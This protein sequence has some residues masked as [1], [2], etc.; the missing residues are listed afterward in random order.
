[1][2]CYGPSY[3]QDDDDYQCGVPCR[4]GL[5]RPPS[6]TW[7]VSI[8]ASETEQFVRRGHSL[9]H[10]DCRCLHALPPVRSQQLGISPSSRRSGG[11]AL[12][13]A[14]AMTL[15][16]LALELALENPLSY[17][18]PLG[19]PLAPLLARFV[20]P[21]GRHVSAPR[22]GCVV[23]LLVEARRVWPRPIRLPL[24]SESYVGIGR[25][26]R[27]LVEQ[28]VVRVVAGEGCDLVFCAP[29]EREHPRADADVRAMWHACGTA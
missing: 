22:I 17:V 2:T 14:P 27:R 3:E 25:D 6:V 8:Y 28:N 16:A 21:D 15:Q 13:R 19:A 20:M 12:P 24:V 18:D 7:D 23:D 10:P 1:M 26:I 29:P 4:Q 9:A 5:L 11:C